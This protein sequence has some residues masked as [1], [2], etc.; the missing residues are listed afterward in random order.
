MVGL[1][2]FQPYRENGTNDLGYLGSSH[3]IHYL[4]IQ[5]RCEFVIG[6]VV[7]NYIIQAFI[8][9]LVF[10]TV[11]IIHLIALAVLIWQNVLEWVEPLDVLL[12]H[13]E[14]YLVIGV[15]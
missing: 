2:V 14:S 6:H 15:S 13:F 3:V 8:D 11:L 10:Q 7:A 9:I 5:R 1:P 12:F 4:L